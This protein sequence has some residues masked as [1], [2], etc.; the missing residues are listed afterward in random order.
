MHLFDAQTAYTKFWHPSP[1]GK[2]YQRIFPQKVKAYTAS[3]KEKN[4]QYDNLDVNLSTALVLTRVRVMVLM[5]LMRLM[6]LRLVI[7]QI[8]GLKSTLLELIS[9]LVQFAKNTLLYLQQKQISNY[10]QMPPFFLILWRV[11]LS[12]YL[13]LSKKIKSQ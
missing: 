4:Q 1:S 7:I 11:F 3:L 8:Q 13:V 5:R 9:I 10:V 6:M 2:A 12:I